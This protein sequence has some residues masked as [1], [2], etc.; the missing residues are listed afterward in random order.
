ME[1]NKEYYEGLDKRTSEYKTWAKFNKI[2]NE[3]KGLGFKS[4]RD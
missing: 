2:G 1:K 4:Y 3:S